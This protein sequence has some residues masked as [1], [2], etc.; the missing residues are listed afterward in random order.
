[1]AGHLDNEDLEQIDT[2]N[3]ED[4]DLKSHVA[5]LIMR[6]KRFIKKIRRNLNFNGKETVG[7]DKT[8]K[9]LQVETLANA[10][11]VQDG[12]GSYDWSFQAEEDHTNFA[13]MAYTSQEL[14]RE[15]KLIV[16]DEAP[17]INR[18]AYE[19]FGGTL[20]DICTE[21]EDEI[22]DFADW[23]MNIGEGKIDGK[24][25][26]HAKVEFPEEMPIPDFNDH[27]ESLITETYDNWQ[28]NL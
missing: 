9:G 23:I 6:M 14:I 8:K 18:L 24:N 12:I 7:L 13:L 4:M 11:V 25:D 2:D 26:G 28:H 3:L 17:M 1:M 22:N 27:I 21:D 20:R 16:W 5:M 10:L 15:T 19:A